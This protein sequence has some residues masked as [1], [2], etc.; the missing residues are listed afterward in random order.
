VNLIEA[1]RFRAKWQAE[2]MWPNLER[3]RPVVA[4]TGGVVATVVIA[5]AMIPL[6]DDVTRAVPVL[7]LVVPIVV[8]S[9]VGGRLAGFGVAAV[10]TLA[11]SFELEPVGSPKVRLSEDLLALAIFSAV[12]FVVSALVTTRVNALQRL[13]DQR[14]ALLRS[15]SHDLR[16]P[17]AAVHAVATDLRAGTDYDEPTRIALLDV[18]VDETE[19]LDRLVANLLSMSR[20]EAGTLQPQLADVD[21]AELTSTSANRMARLFDAWILTVDVPA[22]LPFVRADPA[23]LE[24]VC[25]NLLENTVEHTPAATHVCLS[26]RAV[27]GFVEIRVTDDGPGLPADVANRLRER[28]I[29]A[30]QGL[31]L[32]ICQAVITL[33]GGALRPIA[34][35]RGTCIAVTV[36]C[37]R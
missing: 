15:V 18:M 7:L 24:Q 28:R 27:E 13:D 32:A 29:D 26:A 12:A 14:R 25:N 4:L 1:G 6:E 35:E 21:V 9:V 2:G 3:P 11:L 33:H 23:Q 17:L 37:I 8:A 16:T 20:I 10:A 30:S 31:G 5:A 22:D 19:R 34:R 36:P